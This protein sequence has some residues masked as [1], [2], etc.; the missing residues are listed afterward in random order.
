MEYNDTFSITFA[1]RVE[2]HV[3]MQ[4]IGNDIK[5]GLGKKS[6]DRC[7]DF[8]NEKSLKYDLYDLNEFLPEEAKNEIIKMEGKLPFTKILVIRNGIDEIFGYGTMDKLYEEQK[9]M[10]C[11][12][13][14]FMRGKVVNKRARWNNCYADFDQ[15]PDYENKK[16]TVI[17]FERV[18]QLSRVRN[19]LPKIF[20]EKCENLYAEM[21]YYYDLKHTYIGAHGDSERKIVI[22]ARLGHDMPLYYQWFYQSKKVSERVKF[23]IKG[24]DIY[25]M[26]F[27]AT[28][29]DWKKRSIYTIRH[30]A[31]IDE[32]LIK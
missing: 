20:G 25:C 15:E 17:S 1:E 16:G 10:P 22:C 23:N 19:M 9:K 2:N 21:N 11:D 29:N 4:K 27:K 31:A 6:F 3:G 26:S 24:G 7:I 14:A 30:A 5:C 13:K 12:K 8:C 32:K 28:G 18:P